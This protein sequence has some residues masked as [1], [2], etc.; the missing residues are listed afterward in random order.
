MEKI[1]LTKKKIFII[2][3]KPKVYVSFLIIFGVALF[4]LIDNNK[5]KTEEVIT[6]K[7][8][9]V[10]QIVSVSGKT[11]P[12]SFAD[13]S[14]EKNGKVT[15]VFADV[16]DK[17]VQGQS[18]VRLDS[19]ELNANLLQMQARLS[20]E[21]SKLA[22]ML[23]GTRKEEL[24]LQYT[25][26]DK[27]ESDL[28]SAK[29]SLLNKIR[30]SYTVADDSIRNKLYPLFVDPVR[31]N[32]Y[33]KFGVSS[34]LEDD[35]RKEKNDI[36]DTLNMW[37]KSLNNLN[38]SSDIITYYDTAKLNLNLTKNLLDDSALALSTISDNSVNTQA[39]I[40]TWK[41]GIST[42]RTNTNTAI[43]NLISSINNY[44]ALSYSYKIAKDELIVKESGYTTEQIE[45][46][47]SSVKSAMAQVNI[48]NA[49]LLNNVIFSPIDGVITRQEA[50]VGEI[51]APNK[52]IVSVMSESS[53]EVEAYVPE[54]NVGKVMV[55]NRAYMKLDAFSGERFLGRVTYIE[56][57]ETMIDNIPNFKLKIIFDKVDNRM[58]SGLTVDI[59]IEVNR[60][61]NV[62]SIPR[63][64]ITEID[65][66]YNVL[67]IDG[68]NKIIK[69][70]DIGIQG[71]NGLTE[72][73][74]GLDEGDRVLF[75]G[76]L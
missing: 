67:K 54:I 45:T 27:A 63:Y 24:N 42:A 43:S 64:A 26:T 28:E 13:L 29:S 69:N 19:G 73:I 68:N 46:Q 1:K 44:E 51:V 50:K 71:D 70:I 10:I 5:N 58:K 75:S 35:I 57:A 76:G 47:E 4:F 53:F 36:E 33:L 11:K 30:D 61:E 23:K 59:D 49:Q 9:D 25:K 62:L 21:E 20:A 2:A 15:Y 32:A 3:K 65:G 31:Y 18:I 39:E 8:D 40:D 38:D 66:K 14:F 7:R 16:G 34:G 12:V 17:V 56:P 72:I 74:Y 60:K 52:V 55:G 48:I 22:E 6:V 41:L 37:S